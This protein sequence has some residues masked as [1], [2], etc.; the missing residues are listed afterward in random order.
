MTLSGAPRRISFNALPETIAIFPLEGALLLPRARLPLNIFEP[1][2]LAMVE[3]AIRTPDRIIGMIQPRPS[4]AGEEPDPVRPRIYQIGC[5]GRIAS[6]S[7]TDDG[8]YLISLTGLLRFRVREELE[9]FQPYRRVAADWSAFESDLAAPPRS[10][11][12]AEEH[13]AFLDLLKR[14]FAAANLTADWSDLS[15]ADEETLVNALAMLTGFTPQEKQALLEAPG[16]AD[17]KRD[18]EALMRFTIA[19]KGGEGGAPQ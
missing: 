4:K 15:H 2:Y 3:D 13:R 8:R 7:E 1:R 10:A 6:F 11:A 12:D 14:Y 19:A 18:L 9:G 5:A 17:R 16:L